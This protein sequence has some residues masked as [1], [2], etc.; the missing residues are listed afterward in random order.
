MAW[1]ANGPPGSSLGIYQRFLLTKPYYHHLSKH[2][3]RAG[4]RA[5]CFLDAIEPDPSSAPEW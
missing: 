3:L 5:P 1:R 2:L 4:L